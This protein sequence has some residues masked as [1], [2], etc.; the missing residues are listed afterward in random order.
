MDKTGLRQDYAFAVRQTIKAAQREM[1]GLREAKRQGYRLC[2]AKISFKP[3][4]YRNALRVRFDSIN[5]EQHSILLHP[6]PCVALQ[7]FQPFLRVG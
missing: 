5:G 7:P 3:Q 6:A 2:R 1:K 4:T